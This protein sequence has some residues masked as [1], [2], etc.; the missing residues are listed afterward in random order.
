MRSGSKK[1]LNLTNGAKFETLPSGAPKYVGLGMKGEIKEAL[2]IRLRIWGSDVR[3][4]PGAPAK[5][6]TYRESP[7]EKTKLKRFFKRF[8]FIENPG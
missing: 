5:S 4:V 7:F 6:S 8:L 2:S 3:I 1:A